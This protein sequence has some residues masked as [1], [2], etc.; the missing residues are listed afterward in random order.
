MAFH[1]GHQQYFTMDNDAFG[2]D[3]LCDR[4]MGEMLA[5]E[6][7]F[8]VFKLVCCDLVHSSLFSQ[9]AVQIRARTTAFSS[10]W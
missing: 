1:L 4:F 6:E 7:I 2:L 8:L 3:L 5:V 10:E 9:T